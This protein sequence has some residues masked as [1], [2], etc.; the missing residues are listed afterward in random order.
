MFSIG[1]KTDTCQPDY[2]PSL[3]KYKSHIGRRPFTSRN[4]SSQLRDSAPTKPY[5]QGDIIY[6][7]AG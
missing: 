1:A 4:C 2:N 7:E 5:L 3:R 6:I